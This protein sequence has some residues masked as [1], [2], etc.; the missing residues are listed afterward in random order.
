MIFLPEKDAKYSIIADDMNQLAKA[1]IKK[2]AESNVME[3]YGWLLFDQPYKYDG[4]FGLLGREMSILMIDLGWD[5]VSGLISVDNR[6]KNSILQ[7]TFLVLGKYGHSITSAKFTFD[8]YNFSQFH[9]R[10]SWQIEI[11]SPLEPKWDMLV[12]L[13]R[14]IVDRLLLLDSPI[15][16]S[17]PCDSVNL[18][19]LRSTGNSND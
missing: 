16:Y 3:F 8:S 18:K 1:H 4:S 13:R 15:Y 2:S 19:F 14:G 5:G 11:D 7:T 17:L 9:R 6:V 12:G 10:Y